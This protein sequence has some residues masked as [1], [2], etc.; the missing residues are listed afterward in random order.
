MPVFLFSRYW[1][2]LNERSLKPASFEIHVFRA[3][4]VWMPEITSAIHPAGLNSDDHSV[5]GGFV[6]FWSGNVAR[7]KN[8]AQINKIMLKKKILLF[9]FF[10]N[11]Y[12]I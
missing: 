2:S 1:I 8:R 6:L 5:E 7:M 9:A 3:T 12:Q 11:M 4:N 10:S